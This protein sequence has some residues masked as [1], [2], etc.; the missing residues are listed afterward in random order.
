MRSFSK[1]N[2]QYVDAYYWNIS[3]E[4]QI[5]P[6]NQKRRRYTLGRMES[7][8]ILLVF[9]YSFFTIFTLLLGDQLCRFSDKNIKISNVDSF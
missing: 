4:T 5:K 7:Y 3:I 6:P 9:F 2:W 8:Q 1:Q